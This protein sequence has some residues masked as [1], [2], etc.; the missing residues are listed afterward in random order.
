VFTNKT[1]HFARRI[2]EHLGWANRFAGVFG[3]EDTP[4]RKPEPAFT[5]HVIDRLGI[6]PATT[7]MIGDSPFDIAAARAGG[8]RVLVV[9]TGSHSLDQLE[10]EDA[11]GVYP[12]FPALARAWFPGSL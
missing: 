5:R 4:W 7:L 8:I 12:D 1:G 11:D 6:D 9:A 2:V 10:L 3:A